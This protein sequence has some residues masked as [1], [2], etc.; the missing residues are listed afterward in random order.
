MTT[1]ASFSLGMYEFQGNLAQ[2][3]LTIS[4]TFQCGLYFP[5]RWPSVSDRIMARSFAL[6]PAAESEMMDL[7]TTIVRT[8]RM[9]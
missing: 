3:G 4:R 8:N 6:K 7:H 1:L 9:G 2:T 5:V